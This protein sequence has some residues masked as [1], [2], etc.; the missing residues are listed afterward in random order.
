NLSVFT[1]G[2]VRWMN[3]DQVADTTT[4]NINGPSSQMDLNGFSDTFAGVTMTGGTLATGAGT[5]HLGTGGV[6]SAAATTTANIA[7]SLDLGALTRTFSVADGSA[8]DDLNVSANV[9][10]AG[11]I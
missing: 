3:N 4:L 2:V 7:G 9:I 5:L 8:A 6:T 11:G 1:G 10:G